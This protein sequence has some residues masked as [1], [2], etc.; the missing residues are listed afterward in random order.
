MDAINSKHTTHDCRHTF[1]TRLDNEGA[2]YNAK[3]LL[4]GHA[5]SNVTDGVYTHK[6]LGQL[7]KA[8]RLLK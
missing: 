7:R 4:L 1:T 2:N 8:I 5:S 3:R 6:S